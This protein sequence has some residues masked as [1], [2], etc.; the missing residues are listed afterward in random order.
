MMY[1]DG[2][3]DGLLQG[4]RARRNRCLRVDGTVPLVSAHSKKIPKVSLSIFPISER[5][6]SP[7]GCTYRDAAFILVSNGLQV[8]SSRINLPIR[9]P[10]TVPFLALDQVRPDTKTPAQRGAYLLCTTAAPLNE[11]MV[12]CGGSSQR[13]L[14][15]YFYF[16]S[17]FL[18]LPFL[19]A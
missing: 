11:N 7:M 5:S 16:Y 1:F 9:G 19:F 13:E 3:K 8:P 18:F 2:V 4:G 14:A 10:I 6:P 12:C 17:I 15:F